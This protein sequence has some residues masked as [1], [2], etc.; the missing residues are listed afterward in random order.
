ME[1]PVPTLQATTDLVKLFSEPSR[2][3]LLALLGLEELSVAELVLVSGL[4]QSR[5]STHLGKLREAGL[6]H[7][8]RDGGSSYYS[9]AADVPANVATMWA[10]VYSQLDDALLA[11]DAERGR[12]VVASRHGSSWADSVAGR[13][14]RH[15]SPGR[16][17]HAACRGL[18]GLMDLGRVLDVASGDGAL[19]ELLAPRAEHITCLDRSARIVAAGSARLA[20]VS[21]IDFVEGDMHALPFDDGHFDQVLLMGALCYAER[22]SDVLAEVAR[23][24]RPGGALV[25][26]ALSRHAHTQVVARYDHV[27]LG[28]H[29]ETLATW[30]D[31]AGFEVASCAPSLRE[32]KPPHFQV[33]TLH[34]RRRP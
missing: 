21:N 4:T 8:R 32:R 18:T 26:T 7:D 28:F 3:R 20:E 31:E 6:V 24:T 1:R 29:A 5:V 13:M 22:P 27:Q 30:L 14:A 19:A 2:V 34:A 15:Y 25:G 12:E 16:T 33:L 9:T 10:V 23:V 17:W 11:Q